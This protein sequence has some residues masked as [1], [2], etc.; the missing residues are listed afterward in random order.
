MPQV[1]VHYHDGVNINTHDI[2]AQIERKLIKAFQNPYRPVK[3][4]TEIGYP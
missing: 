2:F 4:D 3:I 1:E